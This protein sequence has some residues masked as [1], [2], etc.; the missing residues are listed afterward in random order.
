MDSAFTLEQGLANFYCKGL[1][2]NI[3]DFVGHKASVAATQ[4]CC[5]HERRQEEVQL[6]ANKTL[7]D[8]EIQ[9]T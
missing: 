9:K 6:C 5:K 8:T 1:V 3:L 4:L 2:V 7:Y